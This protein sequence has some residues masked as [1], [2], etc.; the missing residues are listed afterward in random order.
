MTD[1][2]LNKCYNTEWEIVK[3][4]VICLNVCIFYFCFYFFFFSFNWISIQSF[5]SS[6]CDATTALTINNKKKW[7][8]Y[9]NADQIGH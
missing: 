3:Q 2:D 9:N 6:H 1:D 8:N 5:L 7:N 4:W